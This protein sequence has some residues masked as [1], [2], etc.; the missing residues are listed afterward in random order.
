MAAMAHFH[1]GLDFARR[2]A[3]DSAR[4]VQ[5]KEGNNVGKSIGMSNRQSHARLTNGGVF[6]RSENGRRLTGRPGHHLSPNQRAVRPK[7]EKA[8]G[9]R[10]GV[11]RFERESALGR[12]P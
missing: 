8:D 9:P 12:A 3:A 2:V 6:W 1:R 5:G 4:G 7:A 10:S 11:R